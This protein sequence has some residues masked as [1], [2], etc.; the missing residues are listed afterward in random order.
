MFKKFFLVFL[1]QFGDEDI[2]ISVFCYF[3]AIEADLS[4][5]FSMETRGVIKRI[6]SFWVSFQKSDIALLK[7]S[8]R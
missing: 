7:Q 8:L 3:M 2:M 1:E 5:H 4:I 6:S